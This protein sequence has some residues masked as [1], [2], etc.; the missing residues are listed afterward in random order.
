[1]APQ[2]SATSRPTTASLPENPERGVA[3]LNDLV[4]KYS[5]VKIQNLEPFEQAMMQVAGIRAF[6]EALDPFM[7]S[8]MEL[9]GTENG[10]LTDRDR[11]DK[12]PYDS[13]TVRE[14]V[15]TA[16]QRGLKLIGN[17]F[18]I[19]SGRC[20]TTKEGYRS[21][22]RN[23]DG[24]SGLREIYG[25]PK[26]AGQGGAIVPCEAHWSLNGGKDSLKADIAVRLAGG[27]GADAAVGKAVRKLLARV[28]ARLTGSEF[29]ADDA[30][31]DVPLPTLENRSN[32][33]ANILQDLSKVRAALGRGEAAGLAPGELPADAILGADGQEG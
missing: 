16:L 4:K 25:V 14:V 24:L 15:I 21:L 27:Q 22:V 33:G 12:G 1:M 29:T 11:S 28:Y 30:Q 26:V 2:P 23:F 5:I 8:V 31:D 32:G 18:N 7:S 20:Y 17:E 19:I 9:M 3:V 13:R 10:F 6:R